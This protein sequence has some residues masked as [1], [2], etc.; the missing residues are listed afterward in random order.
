[1]RRQEVFNAVPGN[2]RD[3]DIALVSQ[4]F[5]VQVGQTKCD[6]QF[7]CQ[8]PLCDLRILFNFVEELEVSLAL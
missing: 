3:L 1:V 5:E 4:T 8:R 7:F 2:G 6:A